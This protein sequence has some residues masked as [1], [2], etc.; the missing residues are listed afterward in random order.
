M[1]LSTSAPAPRF[2]FPSAPAALLLWEG[3]RAAL[4]ALRQALARRN[5]YAVVTGG[6]GS[7]KTAL[8]A[9]LVESPGLPVRTV[10]I[11]RPD[12]V[13]AEGVAKI[14]QVLRDQSV[15][16]G[17]RGT[18]IVVD[19]AEAASPELLT[20]LTRLASLSPVGPRAAQVILAGRPE[21]WDRIGA[22]PFVPLGDRIGL[23]LTLDG[24]TGA[25]VRAYIRQLLDQP[26]P[27]SGQVLTPEAEAE[28]LRLSQGRPDRVAA[29]LR[30]T[31]S[32][33]DMT[34]RP[35]I[36]LGTVQGAAAALDGVRL[37]PPRPL[38]RAARTGHRRV[39]SLAGSALL[40]LA[41][42]TVGA[43]A[44]VL[45]ADV[46]PARQIEAAAREVGRWAGLATLPARR[47]GPAAVP[48]AAPGEGAPGA[49]ANGAGAGAPL[50]G[51]R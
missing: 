13:S 34:A 12:Q 32:L 30:S 49:G 29:I 25:E 33:A 17:D 47:T 2:P 22:D 46:W 10:N 7:G 15:A 43:T 18:A 9:E 11:T 48:P 5:A 45:Y 23:R 40:T 50:P 6:P 20:F 51:A 41:S 31:L 39:A 3:Q 44:V 8:L 35:P 36:A 4:D 21:L 24:L 1:S 27:V 28:V 26:R 14:E 16:L 19:N 37:E 38:P 42:V